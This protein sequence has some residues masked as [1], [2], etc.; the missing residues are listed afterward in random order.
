MYG[1]LHNVLFKWSK[2]TLSLVLLRATQGSESQL[3]LVPRKALDADGTIVEYAAH[4][5]SSASDTVTL[6]AFT[7]SSRTLFSP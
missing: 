4:P 6:L 7:V 1:L 3:L 5:S 2:W